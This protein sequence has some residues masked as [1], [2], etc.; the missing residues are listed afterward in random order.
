MRQIKLLAAGLLA[1]CLL[2]ACQSGGE[3]ASAQTYELSHVQDMAQAG[4]F[5]ESLEELDGD[6]AFALYRLADYG[7]SREDL[8]GCAVLRSAGATCEEGAVLVFAQ[9]GDQ[10]LEQAQKALED[11]IQGQIDSN[12][13]YRPNEIPKLENAFIDRR[14]QALVMVVAHDLEAAKTALN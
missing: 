6:T 7:L 12:V 1:L 10:Q 8:T 11:Y 4:A 5:S 14:G 3:E 2:A 13:D 9:G